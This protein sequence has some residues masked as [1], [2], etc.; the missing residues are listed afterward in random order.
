V[1]SRRTL[2]LGGGAT[3]AVAV[4]AGIGVEQ[5]VL[6]GRPW[7]QSRLG[8]NG[9]A[10]TVPDVAP[11]PVE[12]GSFVSRHRLGVDTRWVVVRPPDAPAD[13]PVVVALHGLHQDAETVV[14]PSLGLDRYL[15]AAVA[16]GVA[17]F[18]VAAVDGGTSYWHP[19]PDDEDTGAMVVDEFLPLLADQGLDVS[20]I[21]L[22]GW[23]MGGY[24][25]L[26]LGGVLGPDRVAAVV[27]A[28]PA[29]WQD[30]HAASASGFADAAEYERFTVVG[31][32][33][34][35]AGIAV[36]ID[37]GTGD[38]FYR[39]VQDYA[40]SLDRSRGPDGAEL[41]S[42]FEPGAHTPAYWRRMLP[43][44]LEFLGHGVGSTA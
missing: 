4:G 9:T 28:S 15:A 36:R 30:P 19:R 24:G 29:I 1:L 35:L 21:G 7:V 5:G 32:Q 16:D 22:L 41:V 44:E 11:G 38:P 25:A 27:A 33:A 2:L 10:G 31:H 6:P 26:R 14:G 20:R 34:D 23:S 13:L 12:R 39:D 17:P 43:A 37:C 42:T 40:D 3:A 8:L 18:A